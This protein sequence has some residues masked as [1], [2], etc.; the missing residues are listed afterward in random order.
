M[1]FCTKYYFMLVGIVRH[2][3]EDDCLFWGGKKSLPPRYPFDG[4]NLWRKALFSGQAES[5][6]SSG[7]PL[8]KIVLGNG[9]FRDGDPV[10]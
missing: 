6:V 3:R 5:S 10:G 9:E 1:T 7:L 2:G 8:R 4:G